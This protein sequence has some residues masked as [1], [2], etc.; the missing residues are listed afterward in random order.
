MILI[1]GLGN[2]GIKYEKTI[3]NVG[4]MM[5]DYIADNLNV[6]SKFKKIK[7]IQA[8]INEGTVEGH[9]V[10]LVKPQTYM[11]N[12]GIAVNSLIK[13]Y[14]LFT[15]NDL[16]VVHDDYDIGFGKYKKQ[17]NRGPSGHNGVKS[18]INCVGTKNF[19]RIRIGVRPDNLKIP[20]INT[21]KFVLQ[22]F[23][24]QK[25]KNL[26]NYIFPEILKEINK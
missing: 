5:L 3:H 6:F 14:K 13:A 24:H 17:T 20:N 2:P 12:S 23:T 1:V 10:I 18:I 4:F 8:E 22:R 15:D 19:T 11:N 26:E 16:I 25:L 7:N 9:K 21:E